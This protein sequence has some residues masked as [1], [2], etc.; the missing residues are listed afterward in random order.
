MLIAAPGLIA[1]V[2]DGNDAAAA[3][4]ISQLFLGAAWETAEYFPHLRQLSH[5]HGEFSV[6]VTEKSP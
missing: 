4:D 1:G 5:D 6:T 3:W 2:H